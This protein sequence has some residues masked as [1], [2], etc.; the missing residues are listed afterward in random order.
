MHLCLVSWESIL[1]IL[2]FV[3]PAP[4]FAGSLLKWDNM[5]L[6]SSK[7]WNAILKSTRL[8]ASF[9]MLSGVF[10]KFLVNKLECF[11][12]VPRLTFQPADFRLFCFK[13]TVK[14]LVL[15]S[16]VN[17]LLAE[18][19]LFYREFAWL[20]Q[21]TSLW[22]HQNYTD[23]SLLSNLCL[24]ESNNNPHGTWSLNIAKSDPTGRQN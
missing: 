21:M 17:V 13:R 11:R 3:I 19:N 16:L 12:Y 9:D 15:E 22:T 5:V 1:V 23:L 7:L 6:L 24:Q 2:F 4:W 14:K 20:R 18:C 10:A 8:Q